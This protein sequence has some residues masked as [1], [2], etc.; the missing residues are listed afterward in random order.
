MQQSRTA[1]R[2]STALFKDLNMNYFINDAV[3]AWSNNQFWINITVYEIKTDK[4]H[5]L[6]PIINK[7]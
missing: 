4:I 6:F 5:I 1:V 7:V 3:S 2:F